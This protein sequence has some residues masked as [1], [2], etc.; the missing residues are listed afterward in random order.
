M[1][2]TA[3]KRRLR[4]IGNSFGAVKLKGMKNDFDKGCPDCF[5]SH[6][7]G[8]HKQE[9]H[10]NLSLDLTGLPL[11]IIQ[12]LKIFFVRQ[13]RFGEAAQVREIEKIIL[14]EK[15]LMKPS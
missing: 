5:I 4:T 2:I 10:L 1:K 7:S 11:E 14:K 12:S 8:K 15:E 6:I 13:Q 9:E 3:K